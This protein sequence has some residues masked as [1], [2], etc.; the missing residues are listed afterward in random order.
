MPTAKK[1]RMSKILFDALERAGQE[2][3]AKTQSC[4]EWFSNLRNASTSIYDET[5]ERATKSKMER[6]ILHAF[7][8]AMACL[9]K[10]HS[11]A[12]LPVTKLCI[13]V[14]ACR[15]VTENG[16]AVRVLITDPSIECEGSEYQTARPVAISV[17]VIMLLSLVGLAFQIFKC[18]K[19]W[20]YI[21][22]AQ[23]EAVRFGKTPDLMMN[24][25]QYEWRVMQ[26]R[27]GEA[28]AI[29]P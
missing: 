12:V 22:K 1:R 27:W 3:E 23:F 13:E 5:G 17:L 8:K 2:H 24:I 29:L 4:C 9:L 11:V 7:N 14:L 21:L 26:L 16:K 6:A 28:I 20:R 25:R 18:C 19:V 15:E 10:L